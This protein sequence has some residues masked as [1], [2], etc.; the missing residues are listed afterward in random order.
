[1]TTK[2]EEVLRELGL[3]S[4]DSSTDELVSAGLDELVA[5]RA[6]V[7]MIV[8]MRQS[9]GAVDGETWED[10]LLRY[11]AQVQLGCARRLEQHAAK[12]RKEPAYPG[13]SGP[14]MTQ[15]AAALT[16]GASLIRQ[17]LP[18]LDSEEGGADAIARWKAEMFDRL[19]TGLVEHALPRFWAQVMGDLPSDAARAKLREILEGFELGD[20]TPPE[21]EGPTQVQDEQDRPEGT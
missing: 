19:K 2:I 20:Y 17:N 4:R 3:A 13:Y 12:L 6:V 7:Q 16:G 21:V 18:K 14:P 8:D 9:V 1:M 11:T 15:V 5:T 10:A